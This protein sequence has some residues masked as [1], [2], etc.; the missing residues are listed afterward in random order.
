MRK[1]LKVTLLFLL[2]IML[3][4]G[5]V[6]AHPVDNPDSLDL[7]TSV[8]TDL[9]IFSKSTNME[10]IAHIPE[11]SA[12][13]IETQGNYLYVG[14]IGEGMKIYD[15]SDP[16]S[17]VEIGWYASPG[18][19]ND[20]AVSGKVALLATDP[21]DADPG[22]EIIDI[23]D[24][25]NP[26]LIANYNERRAHAISFVGELAFPSGNQNMD[27]IDLRN[28]SNPKVIGTF[29]AHAT[30]HDV[31]VSGNRAYLAT[32]SGQGMQIV[33]I[34]DPTNPKEVSLTIDSETDYSHETIP[35]EDHSIVVMSD[36]SYSTS[37]PGGELTFYDTSD[38]S[39]PNLLSKFFISDEG[40]PPGFYSAHNFQVDGDKIITAWYTGG[41]RV[42]D[43]SNPANPVEIG[44]FMP[45]GAVTWESLT[46]KG[47]IYTGDSSR[48]IDVLKFHPDHSNKKNN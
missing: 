48:G 3:T 39:D 23:S 27:I 4:F 7:S 42:I 43:I 12:T 41:T 34:S 29:E 15:I 40:M 24:P 22:F 45:D 21:P 30:I 31:H 10:H 8:S 17:P 33:D 2:T 44:H 18:Y 26:T 11:P 14:I 13:G 5:T 47:Y 6:S 46:H 1:R 32:G 35:N 37:A 28:P 36:E 20:V 9:N 19:Q 38:E 16:A 25:T